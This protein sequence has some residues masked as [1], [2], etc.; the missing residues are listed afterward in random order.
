MFQH[1][2]NSETTLTRHN[3]EDPVMNNKNTRQE[4]L[5]LALTMLSVG[6]LTGCEYCAPIMLALVVGNIAE[7]SART[8]IESLQIRPLN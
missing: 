7:T 3:N 6:T 8:I 5:W 2:A 1:V 4:L